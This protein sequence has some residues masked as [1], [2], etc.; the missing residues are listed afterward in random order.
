M[1]NVEPHLYD[2][3]DEHEQQIKNDAQDEH[4]HEVVVGH[5][6]VS[7]FHM[8]YELVLHN[9]L[10]AVGNRAID[11]T[12]FTNGQMF[13]F[14]RPGDLLFAKVK[15]AAD[16]LEGAAIVFMSEEKTPNEFNFATKVCKFALGRNFVLEKTLGKIESHVV[17]LRDGYATNRAGIQPRPTKAANH[18]ALRTRKNGRGRAWNDVTNRTLEVFAQLLGRDARRQHLTQW[19][20][21]GRFSLG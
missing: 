3:I 20:P 10:F 19:R 17:V 4:D 7:V 13:M 8:V 11:Q 6:K 1:L 9:L 15:I 5:S 14:F 2:K 18:V 16:G 21:R 12:E